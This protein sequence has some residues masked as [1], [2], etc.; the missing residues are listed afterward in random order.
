MTQ[1]EALGYSIDVVVQDCDGHRLAVECDGD[2]WHSSESQIRADLYRQ[3]TLENIGWRFHRFLASEWYDSPE[4]HVREILAELVRDDSDVL[5]PLAST[6]TRTSLRASSSMANVFSKHIDSAADELND[7]L[8][9]GP[10]PHQPGE[11]DRDLASS[12]EPTPSAPKKP[13][14]K[15]IKRNAPKRSSKTEPTS[16]DR[17]T[18]ENLVCSVC[19]HGWT[20]RRPAVCDDCLGSAIDLT[21]AQAAETSGV[22]I[23][24]I[25][26]DLMSGEFPNANGKPGDWNTWTIPA[27]DLVRSAQRRDA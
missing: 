3:R 9:S 20:T 21:I 17:T 16:I 12:L 19:Q 15:P 2:R 6:D 14:R 25:K 10:I 4:K 5:T 26:N 13:H 24:K 27:D 23:G 1:V 7:G 22:S 18:R 8:R 11:T